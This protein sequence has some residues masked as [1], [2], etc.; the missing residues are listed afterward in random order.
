M[1]EEGVQ[2]A[3]DLET[4]LL[5]P[6]EGRTVVAKVLGERLKTVGGVDEL[7]DA[8]FHTVNE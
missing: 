5:V 8:T 1:E 7:T 3:A 6:D 4:A 2:L